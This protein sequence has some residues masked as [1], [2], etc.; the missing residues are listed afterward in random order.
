MSKK[1]IIIYSMLVLVPIAFIV[2]WLH[3]SPQLIFI[4]SVLAIIPLA[5]LISE[6]TEKIAEVI[7]PGMGGLLNATFGNATEMVVSIVALRAG[8]VEVVKAS[9]LGTL[10]ANL[11]LGLGFAMFLGGLRYRLQKFQKTVAGINASAL[12]LAV[13]VL[14]TPTVIHITS[15]NLPPATLNNFSYAVS[16]LLLIF[17]FCLLFFSM[18]THQYLYLLNLEEGELESVETEEDTVEPWHSSHHGERSGLVTKVVIL[19][20]ATIFLVFVS[21]ILVGSLEEAIAE[22]GFTQLFTGIIILPLFGGLV[23]YFT[24]ITTA[25]KN[26]MDLSVS[27]GVGSSLQIALFVTPILVFVGLL[28][29]QPMNLEFNTFAIISVSM[30]VLINNSI[31]SDGVSS[32]IEGVLLVL[33]YFVLGTAFYFHP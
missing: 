9:I 17:Y 15:D 5:A 22:F 33:C 20:V 1:D 27:V 19:L 25:L 8:L 13:A 12:F 30:A 21:E 23:E 29:G 11:L 7:G 31:S 3:L 10:L 18:K 16:L 32:W 26:K 14:L 24:C 28:L 2:E 6:S 4:I